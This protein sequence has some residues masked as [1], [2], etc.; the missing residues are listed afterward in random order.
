MALSPTHRYFVA[1]TV[2]ALEL[3]AFGP[4]SAPQLGAAMQIHER[5]ARRML[6]RLCDED[7]VTRLDGPRP[8]YA[9]TMRLVAVAGQS[10]EHASLPPLAAPFVARLHA[11]TGHASHLVTPSYDRVVCVVHSAQAG[12]PEPRL[13]ELVPAHCS[14]GGKALLAQRHRWCENLLRGPLHAY[15]DRTVTDPVVVE[16]QAAATRDRGYA[17]EDGEYRAGVR[18]VAAPIHDA[19]GEAVAAIGISSSGRVDAQLMGGEVSGAAAALGEMLA[20]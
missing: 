9:L 20:L 16:R 18:A 6:H 8:R 2:R 11:A 14:A 3:L 4:L 12:V 13:R 10:L 19:S 7:Y 17:V 5:T 1:R 15:T